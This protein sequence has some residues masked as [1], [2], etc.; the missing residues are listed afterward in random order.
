MARHETSV[1]SHFRASALELAPRATFRVATLKVALGASIRLHVS[2][3]IAGRR[4]MPARAHAWDGGPGQ[5][6]PGLETGSGSLFQGE[7]SY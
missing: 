5:E 2:E 3:N 4:V 7:A 1:W 6:A